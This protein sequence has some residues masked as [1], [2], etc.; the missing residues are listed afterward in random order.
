MIL[1]VQS[2]HTKTLIV[3]IDEC[4]FQFF[5]ELMSQ[6][7]VFAEEKVAGHERSFINPILQENLAGQPKIPRESY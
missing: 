7:R 6:E 3:R 1:E 5:D 2:L 4:G